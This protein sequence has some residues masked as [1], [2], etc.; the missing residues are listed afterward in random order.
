[1]TRFCLFSHEHL[2]HT[3]EFIALQRDISHYQKMRRESA[4]TPL[5]I[6]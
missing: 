6:R 3:I 5:G 4:A 2:L 1:M